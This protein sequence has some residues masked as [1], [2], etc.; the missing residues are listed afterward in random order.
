MRKLKKN[1]QKNSKLK[2]RGIT[3]IALVIT[4]IILIILATISITL[5][6]GEGG[7]IQRAQEG[8]A[9]TEQAQKDEQDELKGAEEFINDVLAENSADSIIKDI[10]ISP[11]EL[12]LKIGE[13]SQL[14]INIQPSYISDKRIIWDSKNDSVAS[15]NNDGLVTA[16]SEG[17]TTITATATDGSNKT[18]SCNVIVKKLATNSEE[19]ESGDYVTYTDGT[20]IDRK[21]AVLYDSSSEY[22]VQIITMESV[23][24]IEIGNGTGDYS[25]LVNQEKFNIAMNSYNNVINFLNSKANYYNNAAYSTSARCV[26]SVPNNI[27]YQEGMYHTEFGGEYDEKFRGQDENYLTDYNQMNKLGIS[28]IDKEYWLASRYVVPSSNSSFFRVRY[29]TEE[30]IMNA[31]R[32]ICWIWSPEIINSEVSF[33]YISGFRPVFSLNAGLKITGGNGTEEK[34]Y[35]LGK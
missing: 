34:P 35:A 19:L 6:F 13:S 25:Q 27:N 18:A 7:L 14:T 2:E 20:G 11:T 5:V 9:L 30:G 1:F 22:G 10:T 15:V 29:V 21:C 12:V 28:S 32:H 4:I 24:N 17:N 8:K 3:L 16:E 23:E 26:G 33:S 31:G